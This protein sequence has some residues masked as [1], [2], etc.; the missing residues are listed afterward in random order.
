M[1]ESEIRPKKIFE[2]YLRLAKKDA[3]DYFFDSA[4]E[5]VGCPA[6][7]QKGVYAFTKDH[8]EYC[9]CLNCWTLF[10]NPRPAVSSFNDYYKDS[11]SSVFWAT[12]FYK[13]TES[14]RRE[15]NLETKS[16]TYKSK[17]KTIWIT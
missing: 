8:F 13:K 1:N 10:V 5:E 3:K 16:K 11:P 17:I 2:E 4:K 15:K 6:C 9:D 14:A 12:T 7:N